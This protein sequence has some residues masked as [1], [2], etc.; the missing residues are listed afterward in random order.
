MALG[1]G[2]H[3]ANT[4]DSDGANSPWSNESKVRDGRYKAKARQEREVSFK[5]ARSLALQL[6]IGWRR[7]GGVMTRRRDEET[8]CASVDRTQTESSTREMVR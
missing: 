6:K 1:H 4:A 3:K 5:V 2:K 7:Q 8:G